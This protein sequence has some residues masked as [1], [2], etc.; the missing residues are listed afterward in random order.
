MLVATGNARR[1]ATFSAEGWIPNGATAC[2]VARSGL[3][4]GP[5]PNITGVQRDVTRPSMGMRSSADEVSLTFADDV[6]R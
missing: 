5:V 4:G 6:H 2:N 1:E 3:A